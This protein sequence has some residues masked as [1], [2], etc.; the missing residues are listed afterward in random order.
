[1]LRVGLKTSHDT[2]DTV[3]MKDKAVRALVCLVTQHVSYAFLDV[4]VHQG[5][6]TIQLT[7]DVRITN[8]ADNDAL[9][10]RQRRT[11]ELHRVR[12]G[13]EF[14][15]TNPDRHVV[16]R[17]KD[18]LRQVEGSGTLMMQVWVG[19]L[20]QAVRSHA[21]RRATQAGTIWTDRDFVVADGGEDDALPQRL[22]D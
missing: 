5:E 6:P 3:G 18:G 15:P 10:T 21:L 20:I 14:A 2:V 11:L 12:F 7:D 13:Y 22:A 9:I 1:M 19:V 16:D 4:P 8:P 17:F